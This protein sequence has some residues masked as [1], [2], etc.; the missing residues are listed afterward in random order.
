MKGFETDSGTYKEDLLKASKK[1]YPAM[2]GF[3]T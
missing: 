1:D 2:K 3:E